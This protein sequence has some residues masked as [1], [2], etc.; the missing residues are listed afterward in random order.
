MS[1][2]FVVLNSIGIFFVELAECFVVAID[3]VYWPVQNWILHSMLRNTVIQWIVAEDGVKYKT[4]LPNVCL[5]TELAFHW[6]LIS[7]NCAFDWKVTLTTV[8]YQK[9]LLAK[10][11]IYGTVVLR[12]SLLTRLLLR[13]CFFHHLLLADYRTKKKG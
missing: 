3:L 12:Y 2:Y 9:Y 11:W 10:L 7:M 1:C 5:L 8:S 6:I 4:L 13:K